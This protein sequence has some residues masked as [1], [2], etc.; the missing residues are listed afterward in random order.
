MKKILFLALFLV[1]TKNVF[2]ASMNMIGE[3]GDPS[4]IDRTIEIRMYDNFYEPNIIKVKK[5]ETIKFVV[6]NLGEMV[7]EYNIATKEMHIKHQ[8][9]MQKLVD[10]GILLVDKIDM[11]KM[12]KMSKKDHSLSHSHS[13]SVIIEPKKTGEMIWK[14]SKN[15]TLEMACN[16]PGHYETGMVGQI[17]VE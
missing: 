11:N 13:N 2:A 14:F 7:H 10:H 4:N 1:F 8:P 3:K 5:G 12:K 9:E 17:I 6:Q 15:L 16:V